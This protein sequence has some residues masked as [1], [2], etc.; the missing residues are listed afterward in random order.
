MNF[1]GSGFFSALI[2]SPR[3]RCHSDLDTGTLD[4]EM[5]DCGWYIYRYSGEPSGC[6]GHPRSCSRREKGKLMRRDHTYVSQVLKGKV[7]WDCRRSA[8]RDGPLCATQGC[9]GGTGPEQNRYDMLLF[10]SFYFFNFQFFYFPISISRF[11]IQIQVNSITN[12]S[13]I[14]LSF[15]YC[16]YHLCKNF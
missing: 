11:S 10:F 14:L 1:P 15:I 2:S 16:F 7:V 13:I 12:A 8:R 3:R 5:G 9:E 4:E 6:N